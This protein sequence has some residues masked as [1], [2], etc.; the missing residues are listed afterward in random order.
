MKVTTPI[1]KEDVSFLGF[2]F[3]DDADLIAGADDVYTTS[4][5]MIAWF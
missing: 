1:S 4:T 5:T 2:L 3:V